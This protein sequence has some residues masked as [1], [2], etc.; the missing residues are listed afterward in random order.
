M[1]KFSIWLEQRNEEAVKEAIVS[2]IRSDMGG[3]DDDE[4]L[5]MRTEEMSEGFHQELLK[6]APVMNAIDPS[7]NNQFID[8]MKQ[9]DTTVGA[10]IAKITNDNSYEEPEPAPEPETLPPE[11]NPAVMPQQNKNFPT[12]G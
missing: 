7:Q 1:K 11:T 5:Q 9:P 10:L 6:L 4:I 2:K 3:G 12:G 8:F